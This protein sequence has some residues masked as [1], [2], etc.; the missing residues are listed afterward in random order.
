[1]RR[2]FETKTVLA[3]A[4]AVMALAV[5]LT[6]VTFALS[7]TVTPGQIQAE[8]ARNILTSCQAANERHDNAISAL[9]QVTDASKRSATPER[10]KLIEQGRANTVL[11]I[12]ALVPRH[13]DCQAVVKSQVLR[14]IPALSAL[15]A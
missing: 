12:D 5:L 3:W 6:A 15:P 13:D 1:M 9:D 11:L 8:R 2:R 14:L 10:V 7:S 4:F